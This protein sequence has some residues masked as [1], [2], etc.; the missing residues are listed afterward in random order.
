[1]SDTPAVLKARM[2]EAF[3]LGAFAGAQIPPPGHMLPPPWWLSQSINPLASQ[4]PIWGGAY[5]M[6][7]GQDAIAAAAA[8]AAAATA[9][10]SF[11]SPGQKRDAQPGRK[12]NARLGE[13]FS[14]KARQ[15]QD[16]VS[17]ASARQAKVEEPILHN[18]TTVMLRHIPNRY[19]ASQL[20][21][22][23]DSHGFQCSYDFVYLPID[24]Q[25][26]VNLGYCFV[27]LAS[28]DIALR[29]KQ[30]LDGFRNWRFD[31]SK[32]SEVSWAHPHQGLKEHIERYRNSPV[33]HASMPAEYKPMVFTNG[34]P[35]PFPAPTKAI[36]APKVRG[37]R[38]RGGAKDQGPGASIAL[39]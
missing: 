36:K 31:S 26:K 39:Q 28:H 29:F 18:P 2:E 10:A 35:M 14:S 11:T 19:T 24:F 5:P 12:G 13:M 37:P 23:L 34:V 15:S 1:M 22:L 21:E 4:F 27:N 3:G 7:P 9:A 33:M 38:E 6:H 17:A 16:K 32:A 20:L 30:A 25:N 8:A